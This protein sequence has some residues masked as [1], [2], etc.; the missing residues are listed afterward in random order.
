MKNP[1]GRVTL[2]S[3]KKRTQSS[4]NWLLRQLNDPFVQQAKK[5]GY[6]SRAAFKLIEI[7]QKYKILKSGQIVIDLGAAPGGWTQVIAEKIKNHGKVI[8]LDLQDIESFNNSNVVILKGDFEEESIQQ[9]LTKHITEADVIVS[10]M[11]AATCGIPAVDHLRIL[12]LL[13]AALNF[14]LSHLKKNGAFVAKVLRGGTEGE[15]LKKLK[16]H[17][18]KVVH[19]KPESSRQD[20]A[21]MY[22]VA[23]GFK[24]V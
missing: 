1:V 15:L 9:E 11:A 17:F 16:T 18:T 7:D 4:R 6:R 24:R 8:A 23:M 5:T 22:V 2:K 10:D 12:N 21:E 20:S 13:E 19:F 14:T 3:K